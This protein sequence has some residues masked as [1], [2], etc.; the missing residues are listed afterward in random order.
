MQKF[1]VFVVF[2]G[3][4]AAAGPRRRA[5]RYKYQGMDFDFI[6][7]HEPDMSQPYRTPVAATDACNA[8]RL[9]AACMR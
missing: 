4:G 3:P 7:V 2:M 5:R 1:D 9:R 8:L 6:R